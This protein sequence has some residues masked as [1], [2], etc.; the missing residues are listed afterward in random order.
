[1]AGFTAGKIEYLGAARR[2][3]VTGVA[4]DT[5]KDIGV[6][7]PRGISSWVWA[8]RA[9]KGRPPQVPAQT[10]VHCCAQAGLQTSADFYWRDLQPKTPSRT[11]QRAFS[12]S[13]RPAP[14]SPRANACIDMA[15]LAS[16][17]TSIVP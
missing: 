14:G 5:D 17:A 11:A 1:M 15:Q 2:L 6:K 10:V 12:N 4:V 7:G 8:Q 9:K 16:E 13:P 3:I